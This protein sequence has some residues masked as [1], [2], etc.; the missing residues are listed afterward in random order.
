MIRSRG[1]LGTSGYFKLIGINVKGIKGSGKKGAVEFEDI[2]RKTDD[3]SFEPIDRDR[4]IV[5]K[6]FKNKF[7]KRGLSAMLHH[8]LKGHGGTYTPADITYES[9]RNPFQAFFMGS[10]SP[11]TDGKNGDE[12][13]TFDES[14][15]QFDANLSADIT[16]PGEGRRGILLSDTSGAFK[17]MSIAYRSTNPY[18]E[19]E[20]VFYAQPTAT[21]SYPIGTITT[22]VPGSLTD[23]DYF[24]I[25]D[26][27]NDPVVF[28]FDTD[29]SWT[30]GR[31]PID[32]SGASDAD[33]VRDAVIEEING[34]M[35]NLLITA[36]NGGA[37]T[38]DLVHDIPGTPHAKTVTE[39]VS[40]GSFVVS[41]MTGGVGNEAGDAK[42]IDNFPIMCVGLAYGVACGD[43]EADNQIG[44][45]SIIGLS[46]TLQGVSDRVYA[47]EAHSQ[48][49]DLIEY[50]YPDLVTTVSDD[51]YIASSTLAEE[52]V[53][54][55][56]P[57]DASDSINSTTREISFKRSNVVGALSTTYGFNR[58]AHV[59]KTLRISNSSDG[60][61]NRDYTIEDVI[62]KWT[63]KVFE[64]PNSTVTEDFM[65]TGDGVYTVYNASKLFDGRVENEGRVS[66]VD[67]PDETGTV[68]LGEYYASE[69]GPGPHMCGRVWSV[70]K[71]LI[72]VRIV[73]P[74]GLNKIYCPDDFTIQ[75]LTDNPGGAPVGTEKPGDDNSWF[76][77]SA[78][79]YTGESGNIYSG[80]AYGYEYTFNSIQCLGVRI[81]DALA[82]DPVGGIKIAELMAFEQMASVNFSDDV[83]KLAI[84]GVPTFRTFDLPNS[85]GTTSVSDLADWLNQVFRGYG[86]E[87]VRSNFGFL[88]IRATVA[89]DRS[90]LEVDSV[91]NG[92]LSNAKIGLNTS[93]DSGTGI[94]QPIRKPPD[95]ALV[96][97]YRVNLTGDVP[98][99][100]A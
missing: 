85:V 86:I 1:L 97:M 24:T 4:V 62:D 31:V 28:E 13:V 52:Q 27:L 83:L 11:S 37:A 94:T 39:N 78:P 30:A 73:F 79:D 32:I 49:T 50:T 92:S 75:V 77:V 64:T 55:D 20:Y 2:M 91:A 3:G 15:S 65:T 7:T 8:L 5:D 25:D 89:G 84:D 42:N 70:A 56:I 53:D 67:D 96:I 14:D 21:Y 58:A 69:D 35:E 6:V 45:R 68:V 72:G 34:Q 82:D 12:K 60:D 93:G 22:I 41:G 71:N 54:S 23:A 29:G 59:R 33:D 10:D 95:E 38:V 9:T 57:G 44:V 99:G 18:G 19:A 26:G 76:D 47:H 46:P 51:G 40:D 98:G 36:S 81:V 61:N 63:V 74:A 87:A 88:W 80:G 43:G 66:I 100:W 90:D 17:R 48:G 16:T